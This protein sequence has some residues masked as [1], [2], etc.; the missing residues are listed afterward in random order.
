MWT[1]HET[2]SGTE[3][4]RY[5]GPLPRRRLAAAA[6]ALLVVIAAAVWLPYSPAGLRDLVLAAGAAAPLAALA[7]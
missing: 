7:A 4:R 6:P 3:A 5:S 2:S 1:T